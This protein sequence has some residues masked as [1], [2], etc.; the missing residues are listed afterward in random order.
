M[1]LLIIGASG[2]GKSTLARRM[3]QAEGLPL[4]DLDAI[5]WEPGKIAVQRPMADVCLD[6][7]AFLV[8][9]D[10]WVVE[11]C[12]GDLAAHAAPRCSRLLF[13]N[14]GI[15]ACVAHN[16][17]RPWEPHKYASKDAQDAMLDTLQQWVRGYGERDDA[18][19]LRAHRALFDAHAG[20][21]RE[22]VDPAAIAAYPAAYAAD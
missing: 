11:G 22:L 20:D 21:K 17:H 14:P 2:S 5:V 13:L 18:W 6:L 8:A 19:S 7:D 10:R 16:T 4:L 1:R 12:Y 3:S 9:N 15:E